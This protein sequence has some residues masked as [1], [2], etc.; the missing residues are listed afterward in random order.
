MGGWGWHKLEALLLEALDDVRDD[1]ALNTV[2]V[3][4]EG[5]K[6]RGVSLR[7]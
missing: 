6:G 1:A 3:Q 7:E 4:R 2:T 5:R